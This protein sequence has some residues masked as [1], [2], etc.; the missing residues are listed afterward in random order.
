[1]PLLDGLTACV[2]SFERPERLAAC[3]KSIEAARIRNV[4]ISNPTRDQDY[5]CNNSWMIAAYRAHTKRVLLIHDDDLLDPA[6][7]DA[8]ENIIGPCLDKRDAGW[9]SWNS[10]L[11]FDD[12][13]RAPSPYWQGGSAVMP[14][15]HFEEL[16]FQTGARTFSPCVSIFNRTILIRAC[17][18]AGETLTSNP[19]LERPGMLL[20]TEIL[21]YLRH[22]QAFKRWL[23]L[24]RVLSYYG[25]HKGSGTVTHQANHTEHVMSAGYDLARAQ[26]RR[27]PPEPTPR[28]IFV[29]S[30]YQPKDPEVAEAQKWA[31]KSWDWHF[32]TAQFIDTPHFD[33]SM[34]TIRTLLDFG[35]QRA[36]PEDIVVY[37]NSDAGLSTHAYERIVAGVE[38]GR[39]VTCIGHH[40]VGESLMGPIKNLTHLKQPGGIELVAMT[41]QWWKLH[42]EKMP[43]MHIGREAWDSVFAVLAEEWA[44]GH[45]LPDVSNSENWAKSRAHTP[46]VCWHKDHFSQWQVER[47]KPGGTQAHNRALARAFFQ[48]RGNAYMV[49]VLK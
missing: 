48:E 37:A 26:G 49:S 39:G 44:D 28:I 14:S 27:L 9:A 18:E 25:H 19:S 31:Q 3:L 6:F 22:C 43:D 41:P 24:D 32:Q 33:P 35:C 16:I 8:Y 7:G 36:L 34:P 5:G 46:N 29:H 1:M 17:K 15:K 42:R 38:R 30:V 20:G 12:G 45:A 21:V 40:T 23:H 4:V 13:T 47:H 2:T 10:E 11:Q